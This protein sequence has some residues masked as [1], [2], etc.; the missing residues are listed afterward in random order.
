MKVNKSLT[1][2]WT[3]SWNA[4]LP[5]KIT[6]I[7]LWGVALIGFAIAV[8]QLWGKEAVLKE[9]YQGNADRLSY[10]V[11]RRMHENPNL[12]LEALTRTLE[13][14]VRDHQFSAAK[15]NIKDGV[16]HIDK[17]HKNDKMTT[18]IIP[19]YHQLAGTDNPFVEIA[20]FHPD[21]SVL[22]RTQ[23]KHLLWF[24]VAICLL[25]GLFLTWIMNRVV[26]KPFEAL[27]SATQAIS[28]GQ[29]DMRFDTNRPDEFGLFARFFNEMLDVIVRDKKRLAAT[30]KELKQYGER[31][32]NMVQERTSDLAIA[33]DKALDANKTKSAFLANMS[34]EIRT[35]LTAIIGFAESIQDN[36]QTAADNDQ[37]IDSIIRN[38]NHL[39]DIINEILDMSKIE[40][41]RL[42]IER[43]LFSP[44]QLIHDIDTIASIQAQEK[45]LYFRIIHI[46]PLPHQVKSDPTRLKQILLNLC[47]N[48][49][50]FTEKGGVKLILSADAKTNM[51]QFSVIDTGIGMSD[52]QLQ[53][54]FQPFT[55]ADSSTTRR[56]G[57]TG[58]GL[59]ISQQL[60]QMLSGSL[61]VSSLD[62]MGT[63]FDV[64]I[65]I[66]DIENKGW[67]QD[68]TEIRQVFRKQQLS[69]TPCHV[70][71]HILLAEDNLDNQQL[72]TMLITP[73][74]ATLDTVD[75]GKK[76]L[77]HAKTNPPD[78]ILM[79]M[80]MP[81]MDGLE[82]T[83][84]LRKAGFK[85]P[86][87][88]LT[89]NVVAQNVKQYLDAGCNDHIAKP[90]DRAKLYQMLEAHLPPA[91]D[92]QKLT[93]QTVTTNPL[94]P[95]VS[96][97]ITT[98]KTGSA[99]ANTT[100]NI[101]YAEDNKNNQRLVSLLLQ[102]TKAKLTLVENGQMAVEKALS[103]HF[104][105]ILMD[106][107]MP[108]MGGLEATK[109]LR[110]AGY[111]GPIM[112]LTANVMKHDINAYLAAGCDGFIPKPIDRKK[113]YK[114]ISEYMNNNHTQV[115]AE[116]VKDDFEENPEYKALVQ[117]FLDGLTITVE[118]MEAAITNQDWQ[119]LK[120]LAHT[121]KGTAGNFGLQ[122]ISN[123]A[124]ELETHA[125]SGDAAILT[126]LHDQL[127]GFC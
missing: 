68:E 110:K 4:S 74:G 71:G 82:A 79:D 115:K 7:V 59:Y 52:Q 70:S 122:E 84:Q 3:Q 126:K 99:V 23:Q 12:T 42:E 28:G 102:K 19:I 92:K 48:A 49:L 72:M 107:Q 66:G 118:N 55:Q 6:T 78:L 24:M 95:V 50:K 5:I 38:G 109:W 83:K 87:M 37:L 80:Q 108:I 96:T 69:A 64:S 100:G 125:I 105:L 1:S 61:K 62:G 35:P 93:T 27:V 101:L 85:K 44:F 11:L 22:L 20:V 33:R 2:D 114:I 34:H 67:V 41:D 17:P 119:Q 97:A 86:I 43:I 9:Q 21:W 57:G 36:T 15:L 90:I 58:L 63:R 94:S 56:Y 46:F 91:Q 121:L 54:L 45:E 106:M 60:T 111:D 53:K 65:D 103:E 14:L 113:F 51:L 127:I 77:E 73:T 40:A 124:L 98:A 31:L 16:I 81:I 25:F 8:V 13:D 104:D 120:F 26:A 29:L 10:Q 18:R 32:E 89:A 39:L 30:N 117:K 88:A 116:A 76:A 75:N 112:A 123:I 47:S